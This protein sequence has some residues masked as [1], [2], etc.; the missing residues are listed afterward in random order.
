MTT[1]PDVAQLRSA[2]TEIQFALKGNHGFHTNRD[3]MNAHL[4]DAPVR[5][6]PLTKVTADALERVDDLLTALPTKG[7]GE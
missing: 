4:H 5:L 1:T 6:S 7:A 3:R 2:L